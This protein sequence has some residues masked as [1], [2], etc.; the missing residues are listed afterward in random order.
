MTQKIIFVLI[1]FLVP[2]IANALDI[3]MRNQL[4]NIEQTPNLGGKNSRPLATSEAFTFVSEDLPAEFKDLFEAGNILFNATW[5]ASISKKAIHDGLG[6]QFNNISCSNCHLNNGR[7]QPP[8]GPDDTHDTMIIKLSVPDPNKNSCTTPLRTLGEQLQEKAIE[9]GKKEGTKKVSWSNIEGTYEDGTPYL[10]R[11]PHIQIKTT[12]PFALPNNVIMS[13]RIGNPII[14]LGLINRVSDELLKSIEDPDDL[15]GDGISG[16]RSLIINSKSKTVVL[17]KFGWKASVPSLI[18][19]NS[20]A[21]LQDLGLTTPLHKSQD[22]FPNDTRCILTY[23]DKPPEITKYLL[24]QLNT[25]VSE[26]AVPKQRGPR[27]PEVIKGKKRFSEANCH[28]CHMP[29]MLIESRSKTKNTIEYIHPFSDLLLH[30]MGEELGEQSIHNSECNNEW[31]TAPLWGIGLTHKVS[32]NS[33]FLHDGRARSIEEA[34]L[35]HNG[36]AKESKEVFRKMPKKHRRELI[37]FLESL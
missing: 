10:L 22:C 31:R 33:Y 36:E 26:L 19:Q 12:H 5:V 13:G 1:I 20:I 35:W 27:L 2:N 15:N 30:D 34:I 24:D 17:G 16:R 32:N 9:G 8:E 14:G 4:L 37:S 28:L 25:Y 7:G 11:K 29:T 23:N 18:Q 21:A 6:P 3:S